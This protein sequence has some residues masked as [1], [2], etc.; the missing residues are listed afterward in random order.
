MNC[1]GFLK[2]LTEKGIAGGI[3]GSLLDNHAASA[4]PYPRDQS[5]SIHGRDNLGADVATSVIDL[6]GKWLIVQDPQNIGREERWF[7]RPLQMAY[8]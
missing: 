2:D 8:R 1:R 7:S 4:S 3:A 6:S 5:Q